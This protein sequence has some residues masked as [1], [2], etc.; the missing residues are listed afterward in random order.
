[1]GREAGGERQAAA[2]A[3]HRHFGGA[4]GQ[5]VVACGGAWG[6]GRSKTGQGGRR[7]EAGVPAQGSEVWWPRATGCP[8]T[9]A[10]R[11]AGRRQLSA[12]PAQRTHVG[13]HRPQVGIVVAWETGGGEGLVGQL[14]HVGGH[15]GTGA[16]HQRLDLIGVGGGTGPGVQGWVGGCGVGGVGVGGA[17]ADRRRPLDSF[18]S[19]L[20]CSQEA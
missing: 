12:P 5:E 13:R 1:M 10:A 9:A 14:K 17:G 8:P 7:L 19:C 20:L 18:K 3:A 6:L 4:G 11:A 2:A 15:A 16:S